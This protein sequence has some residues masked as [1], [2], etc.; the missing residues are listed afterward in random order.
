MTMMADDNTYTDPLDDSAVREIRLR[1]DEE[2]RRR[3]AQLTELEQ[4]LERTPLEQV[5]ESDHTRLENLRLNLTEIGDALHRLDAG[6]YGSCEDCAGPIPA[7]RLEIL[8]YARYCVA[9]QG[10]NNRTAR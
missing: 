1:L 5:E 10:R 7:G 6:S 4:E 2:Q 3:T 9:C 8:P